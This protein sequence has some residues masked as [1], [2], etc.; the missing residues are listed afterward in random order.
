MPSKKRIIMGY[1]VKLHILAFRRRGHLSLP[2]YIGLT[3]TSEA[4][5]NVLKEI[6]ED[7]HFT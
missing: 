1:G 5:I 7:I 4:D 2:D 3:S 6:A